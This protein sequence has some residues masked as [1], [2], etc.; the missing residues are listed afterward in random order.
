MGVY[1]AIALFAIVMITAVAGLTYSN[2]CVLKTMEQDWDEDQ[3][4][5]NND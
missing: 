2:N 5:H 3:W 1:L 4:S